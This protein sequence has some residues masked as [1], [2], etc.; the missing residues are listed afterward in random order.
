VTTTY[1]VTYTDAFGCTSTDTVTVDVFAAYD[2]WLPD[3]FS[4]NGDGTNDVF[5]VRGAGI[6]TLDFVIYDRF[7]EKVFESTSISDGWDG[8][9][10]GE[11]MNTGIY[12][13]YVKAELYNNT[14]VSKKGD[15]SLI[16]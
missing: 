12:V 3:G 1:T 11:P 10:R 15:V 9:F 6:K 5:Y 2:V 16:R 7:G 4:P 8:S 13:W 14:T